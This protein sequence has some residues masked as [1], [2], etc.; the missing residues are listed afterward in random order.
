MKSPCC[1]L[2][3]AF[4]VLLR[5]QRLRENDHILAINCTPLDQ[6]ISHQHAIALLQQS[7]GSLHL[8]VAREPL[9]GNSRTALLTDVN[10]PET[11]S[12]CN[13]VKIRFFG[14]ILIFFSPW[15]L[16]VCVSKFCVEGFF[17]FNQI[18]LCNNI[19]FRLTVQ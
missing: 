16:S 19:S 11:V 15:L 4:N 12:C 14:C 13:T 1:I 8:V 2:K 3:I 18:F 9:Q 5:D 7:T 17:S 6:N 10:P